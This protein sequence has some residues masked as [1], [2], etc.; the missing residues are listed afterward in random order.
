VELI[1]QEKN[2]SFVEVVSAVSMSQDQQKAVKTELE[3]MVKSNV[4]MFNTVSKNVLG[5]FIIKSGE[6]MLDF[7]VQA[8]LD[9]LKTTLLR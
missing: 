7:S 2:S 4:Y 5:G 6:K 3:R 1:G 8:G 9:K